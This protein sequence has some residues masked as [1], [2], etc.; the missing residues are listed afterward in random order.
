MDTP[1]LES[2]SP[3][4]I[5]RE[6]PFRTPIPETK[7]QLDR[8]S[9]CMAKRRF[10]A[11][12]SFQSGMYP[13]AMNEQNWV[14]VKTADISL[15]CHQKELMLP[16]QGGCQPEYRACALRYHIAAILLLT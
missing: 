7:H 10:S 11:Q 15:Q 12:H 9:A 16:R 2:A 14:Q 3:T 1:Q 6:E 8:Q 13:E 4:R 5:R